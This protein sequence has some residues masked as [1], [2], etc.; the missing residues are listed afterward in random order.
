MKKLIR[1]LMSCCNEQQDTKRSER[2][3]TTDISN[4]KISEKLRDNSPNT[5]E[6]RTVSP[7][8]SPNK[9][10]MKIITTRNEDIGS[11]VR[12]NRNEVFSPC[13]DV[14]LNQQRLE[15]F[16]NVALQILK[17]VE[18]MED[19]HEEIVENRV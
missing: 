10:I 5:R 19:S 13:V 8:H 4:N 3:K 16:S 18:E 17:E 11:Q 2:D 14:R 7:T 12:N 9:P 6:V 1:V 15:R